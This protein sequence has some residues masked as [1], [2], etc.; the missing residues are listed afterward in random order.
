MIIILNVH[1]Q[2]QRHVVSQYCLTEKLSSLRI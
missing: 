2:Y 1:P